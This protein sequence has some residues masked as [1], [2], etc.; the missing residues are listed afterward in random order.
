MSELQLSTLAPFSRS[1]SPPRYVTLGTDVPGGCGC[2][3]TIGSCYPTPKRLEITCCCQDVSLGLHSLAA[4]CTQ[5]TAQEIFARRILSFVNSLTSH[6]II[7]TPTLGGHHLA[8]V[9]D[10]C[11]KPGVWSIVYCM[12]NVL[13]FLSPLSSGD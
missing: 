7:K 1:R 5:D 12:H 9:L 2:R 8:N 3:A 13:R 4:F 11:L 6:T 10:K